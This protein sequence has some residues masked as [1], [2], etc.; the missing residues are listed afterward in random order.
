MAVSTMQMQVRNDLSLKYEQFHVN[1]I[2]ITEE[3]DPRFIPVVSEVYRHD[4]SWYKSAKVVK[5]S[6]DEL[7]VCMVF[8]SN[9]K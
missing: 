8:H 3:V 2:F 7:A 4:A 6:A 9:Y 5:A 1:V